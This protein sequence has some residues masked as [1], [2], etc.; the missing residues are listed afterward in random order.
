MF[1]SYMLESSVYR[2][3]A[4]IVLPLLIGLIVEEFLSTESIYYIIAKCGGSETDEEWFPPDSDM[5]QKLATEI[6]S[7]SFSRNRSNS[8]L[9]E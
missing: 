8:L 5:E 1:D 2:D 9:N 6:R 4:Y 3:I 7:Y